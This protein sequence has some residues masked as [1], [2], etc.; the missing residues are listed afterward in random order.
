[1]NRVISLCVAG[2]FVRPGTLYSTSSQ[3]KPNRGSN[4]TIRSALM[5]AFAAACL[6]AAP[7]PASAFERGSGVAKTETRMPGP[8]TKIETSGSVVLEVTSGQSSTVI[9]V[10]GDNNVV[11]LVKTTVSGDVLKIRVDE[12][13]TAKLPLVVK[14][15]MPKLVAVSASG[16][17]KVN[18]A[19]LGGPRF[20]LKGSGA[21]K[22]TL[23]GRV[24]E[25]S[26]DING[27]ARIDAIALAARNVTVSASGA[28]TVD[29]NAADKLNV[30]LSG[31]GKVS[32]LGDPVVTK[33]I[34]AAGTIQR[35]K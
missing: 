26:I 33:S 12:S 34:S 16:A 15:A 27:A 24:D 28:G 7:L 31:A 19:N 23:G 29:V 30:H 14:I 20:E 25:L 22:A 6:L 32:Y 3:M 8:F 11:P 21:V 9:L 17:A 10:S 1:M 13:H 2:L 4:A 5:A 18:A 35:K